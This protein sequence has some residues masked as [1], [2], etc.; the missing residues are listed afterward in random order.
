MF[1]LTRIVQWKVRIK[2]HFQAELSAR[3]NKPPKIS[4]SKFYWTHASRNQ[5]TAWSTDHSV[6][7]RA[8][9]V[10]E[11]LLASMWMNCEWINETDSPFMHHKLFTV[12]IKKL[13]V[14]SWIIKINFKNSHSDSL[15]AISSFFQA[16]LICYEESDTGNIS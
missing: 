1:S 13:N 16:A 10:H 14:T 15:L 8:V 12:I 11:S 4:K 3:L 7:M 5:Q 9:Q 6:L 2:T